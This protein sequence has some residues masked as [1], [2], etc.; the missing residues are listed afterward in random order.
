MALTSAQQNDLFKLTVGLFN[1]APGSFYTEVEGIMVGSQTPAAAA[2]VLIGTPAFQAILPSKIL[3]NTQFATKFLDMLV[4]S[5]VSAA[6][7]AWAVAQMEGKLNNGETQG[8][9]AWWAIDELSKVPTSN[10]DW[11]TAATLLNNKLEVTKH[12]TVDQ[13]VASK[14]IAVLQGLLI[15]VTADVGNCCRCQNCRHQQH[16]PVD[17]GCYHSGYFRR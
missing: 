2:Q 4:G 13:Y 11:G 16:Q 17:C 8:A 7:K 12:F 14:D 3:T 9:V 15:D 6:N 10:A 5:T 1:A